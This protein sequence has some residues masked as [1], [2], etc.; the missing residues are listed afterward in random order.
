MQRTP[1]FLVLPLA[2]ASLAC[3]QATAQQ[4]AATNAAAPARHVL[5]TSDLFPDTVVAK[6]KGVEIKRSQLDEEVIRF[7][8]QAAGRGQSIPTENTSRLEQYILNQLLQVQ[9][10]NAKATDADKATAKKLADTRFTEAQTKLGAEE[11]DREMKLLS[12]SREELVAKWGELGAADAVA[13]RELK[14]AVSDAEVKTYFEENQAKFEQPEMLVASHILLAT[15]D[16]STHEDVS[17]DKK[18]AKHKQA[19]DLLKR[20]RAGED[21]AKLAK[22][23]SEDPGS[24]D[25]GGE[26]QFARGQMVKEFETAAFALNTNQVSDIVTTSF[27]YHIIK[28]REKI[29]AHKTGLE[30]EV[31]VSPNGYLVLKQYIRD[32]DTAKNALKVSALIRQNLE[33][34]QFQKELPAFLERLKKEAGLEILDEKLKTQPTADVPA[35]PEPKPKA[36]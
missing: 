24:K 16:P 34:Q 22:E 10:L 12:T 8:S 32:A 33:G 14:A 28:L 1:T 20:A 18:A 13:K 17:A 4:P 11:M 15:K 5:K 7:K 3:W 9:L 27:G 19:E 6:G 21:F 29:P 36:N 35:L 31:V 26:Y 23:F 25:K 30:D 2:L